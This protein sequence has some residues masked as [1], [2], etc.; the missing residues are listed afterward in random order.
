MFSSDKSLKTVLAISILVVVGIILAACGDVTVPEYESNEADST[1]QADS[2]SSPVV[3]PTEQDDPVVEASEDEEEVVENQYSIDVEPNTLQSD[4]KG[5]TVGFTTDGHAFRGDPVA[6]VVIHEYS[7]FQCPFC[8][9]FYDQTLSSLEEEQ[10]ADGDAVLIYYDFPLE[11]IHP[12]ARLAANAAR[13]AGEQGAAA[14]WGMHDALFSNAQEWGNNQAS[15]TFIGYGE[16]IGLDLEAFQACI[17]TNKHQD[18]IQADL[19]T[20][21]AL[22]ITGT[23]TFVINGQ[24]LVG[25]QPLEVFTDAIATVMDGGQLASNE[26]Q[27]PPD[28][29]GQPAVAPTPAALS[30]EFASS[31]G[32]PDAQ[33]TIVEFTDYQCPFCSRHS[34][35]T[36]PQIISELIDTGRVHYILKDLPLESLHPN[37][38]AAAAAVRCAGD[39]DSYWEM[40]DAVFEAQ[41]QWASEG[42]GVNGVFLE[43][44]TDLGLDG[45]AYETCLAD[46]RHDAE[47]EANLQEARSLGVG[48]TPFF[49]VDGYPLNGARPYEHFEIVTG[50]AEDGQLAEA[51]APSPQ[52]QQP[53]QPQQPAGPQDVPIGDAY[54]IGDPDAPI[55]IVEYTDYQCPFCG[56]HFSETMPQ[57]V[58]DYVDTGTVRYVFKDFPLKNIHP[59]AVE[60]AEA[61][62]CALDQG[63]YLEMHDMLFERQHEWGGGNS[64]EAFIGYAQEIGLDG[65]SFGQCLADGT[66]TAAVDADLAEG[67]ELG[68]TGTPAFFI[69]GY[70][71]SGAQPFS[72]FEGAI[73]SLLAQLEE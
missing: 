52:Q 3:E 60:A 54:S 71:I 14:Y 37:A 23:P 22:G 13:C 33:V 55:T 58:Q 1:S 24:L 43:I 48:G 61:A 62:R 20:G 66:H 32:D 21:S 50:L 8:A 26:P 28:Q 56:R 10:I 34:V 51:F 17:A 44:A 39:Q 2:T 47:I 49:F 59:Q 72:V 9:R 4:I 19:S 67:V 63:A 46:G 68:V 40:H 57:L 38:R 36:M 27:Q 16:Q 41:E 11:Q 6:P 73:S 12:Q 64:T 70:P 42:S 15:E 7:D 25:A 53:E 18:A 65:E 5:L 45:S 31:M 69:N 35:D 30:D 29:G